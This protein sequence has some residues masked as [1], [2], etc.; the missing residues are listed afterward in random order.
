MAETP[1]GVYVPGQK[2]SDSFVLFASTDVPFTS[3][4]ESAT[5][6]NTSVGGQEQRRIYWPQDRNHFPFRT[7]PFTQQQAQLW[8]EWV[9]SIR[10]QG[11]NFYFFTF[12]PEIF[13]NAAA[14]TYQDVGQYASGSLID[15]PYQAVTLA[16]SSHDIF[17][18]TQSVNLTGSLSAPGTGGE[19]RISSLSPTP[20]VNDHIGLRFTGRKRFLCRLENAKPVKNFFLAGVTNT[21]RPMWDMSFFEVI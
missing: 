15:I 3:Q 2:P 19:A 18:I 12:E 14:G 20:A 4:P 13:G 21:P 10:G 7:M 6:I 1:S 11:N 17:N 9:A 8:R 5:G 16:G